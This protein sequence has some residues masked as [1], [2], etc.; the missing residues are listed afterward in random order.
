MI[1]PP[2]VDLRVAYFRLQNKGG[3]GGGGE[4]VGFE[5]KI[6]KFTLPSPFTDVERAGQ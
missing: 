4:V 3:G 6:S 2:S 5:E 1:T